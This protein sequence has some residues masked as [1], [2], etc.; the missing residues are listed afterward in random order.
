MFLGRSVKEESFFLF[1]RE[2]ENHMTKVIA[3]S[4]SSLYFVCL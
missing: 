3:V 4:K 2:V 1:Q